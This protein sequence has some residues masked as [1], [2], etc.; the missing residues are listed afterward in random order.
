M[1]H[2]DI[3]NIRDATLI[4]PTHQ[5][6][7]HANHSERGVYKRYQLYI[8]LTHALVLSARLTP[9]QLFTCRPRRRQ[10]AV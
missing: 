8:Q 9:F 2:G 4:M 5:V 3:V 10:P 6:N 7:E 1:I